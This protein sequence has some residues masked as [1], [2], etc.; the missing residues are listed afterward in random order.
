MTGTEPLSDIPLSHGQTALEITTQW[1][2]PT[3]GHFKKSPDIKMLNL[4]SLL[5]KAMRVT[6]LGLNHSF[7]TSCDLEVVIFSLWISIF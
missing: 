6:T 1:H 5:G 7:T 4:K 2:R 3:E